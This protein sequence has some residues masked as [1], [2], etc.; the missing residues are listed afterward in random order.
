MKRNSGKVIF[1]LIPPWTVAAG[2][3]HSAASREWVIV[4]K[5]TVSQIPDGKGL[6]ELELYGLLMFIR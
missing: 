2:V 4:G 3:V 5:A 6:V 1:L